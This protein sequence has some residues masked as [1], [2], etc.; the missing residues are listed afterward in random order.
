MPVVPEDGDGRAAE[1][2]G[3]VEAGKVEPDEGSD[4][5][6]CHAVRRH[7]RLAALVRRRAGDR[8]RGGRG[9]RERRREVVV[10]RRGG[11]AAGRNKRKDKS[12]RRRPAARLRAL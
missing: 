1:P 10:V 6:S 7:D 8:R 11:V 5:R 4:E 12:E 2:D 9:G 3:D